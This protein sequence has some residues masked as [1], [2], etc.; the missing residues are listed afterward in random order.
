MRVNF[1]TPPSHLLVTALVGGP[2]YSAVYTRITQRLAVYRLLRHRIRVVSPAS[3]GDKLPQHV[4]SRYSHPSMPGE[5]SDSAF[6]NWKH[7]MSLERR[8]SARSIYL[9]RFAQ[10]GCFCLAVFVVAISSKQCD[11]LVRGRFY[12][13]LLTN[14][15]IE[16]MNENEIVTPLG[17]LS[18]YGGGMWQTSFRRHTQHGFAF[19]SWR[20][21][22]THRR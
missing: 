16:E 20:C 18:I 3:H 9:V 21:G 22:I 8:V 1:K 5:K 7:G 4:R 15:V 13:V 6:K 14:V 12:R 10:M 11:E 19:L 17:G 2:P